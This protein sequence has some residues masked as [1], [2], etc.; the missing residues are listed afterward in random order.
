MC[1]QCPTS[2]RNEKACKYISMNNIQLELGLLGVEAQ[3]GG[4][5]P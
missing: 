5:D 1:T 2:V 4:K 3:C